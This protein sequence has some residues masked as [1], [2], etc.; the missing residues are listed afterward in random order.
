MKSA[1]KCRR[2]AVVKNMKEQLA[3]QGGGIRPE[4]AGSL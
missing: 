2:S 3:S 1:E 4:M